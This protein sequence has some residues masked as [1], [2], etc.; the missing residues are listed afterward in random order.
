MNIEDLE[1]EELNDTSFA[2]FGLRGEIIKAINDLG[3]ETPSPIQQKTIPLLLE[4]NDIVGQAQTGT[5]K[6][7]AF[8]LPV[9][10]NI[11]VKSTEVQ[12]LVL[13]PTRELAIQ[14]AEAFHSY[15]KHL[16]K[17]R[18]LPIY[19]GQSISQQIRHLRNGVQIIVG[20]PGRVMDHI[21]RETIDISNLKSV[22]LDEADEMLRM[23]FIE[24]VEWILSHTPETRQTAL[25]SATMPREVRRIADRYLKDAVNVEIERKTLTVPTIKQFYLNVAERQKTDA[26]TRLLETESNSGEAVIIFH[27]TKVGA[28]E[29]ADKLQARGYSAEAMHGDM[30]Q[31]QRETV[32]KRLKNGKVEIVVATDVAARGLDVERIS[33]VINYDMPSDTESYVHRIGRTGR[34]G[35]E[36]RTILFVTPR[37]Q[38]MLRDI[39]NYTKQKITPI[40]LPTQADVAA[41][42]VSLLKEKIISTLTDQDLELYLSLVEDLAEETTCDIAEIAAAA[43]FLSVGDK[44][45]EVAVE[46][47]PQQLSFSEEGMVRL[48]IDVGRR[49]HIS[50]GDIVGAIANEA[51]IPGKAIGAIDVNDRFT[52]VDV[53]NE[54]VEQV[55][56]RMKRS[57]IRKQN[58]N[59]RLASTEDVSMPRERPRDRDFG[60]ERNDRFNRNERNDR[61]ERGDRTERS[62]RTER[63]EKSGRS[64]DSERRPERKPERG[65]FEFK[66]RRDLKGKKNKRKDSKKPF[67]KRKKGK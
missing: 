46:P 34:A 37:Q 13:T 63:S 27:R 64:F 8:A 61:A 58:M 35:R 57:R 60:F 50:P 52:L 23:G 17:V 7:A 1:I 22:V 66:S 15:A 41:R 51:D 30:S 33:T 19:G 43:V 62:Y 25:F 47:E 56:K 36:G 14:V 42:R 44:P 28:A 9:L 29:L 39:E 10:N 12:A 49:H 5:G 4:N 24:D 67:P 18:V 40:K 53:P 31:S 38:R 54:F 59:V 65:G 16:G 3:Y 20:T 45:L 2:Q 6:T 21:R 32:I 26:L 55:L 11:E 48:F